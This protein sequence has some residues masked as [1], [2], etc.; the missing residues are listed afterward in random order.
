MFYVN[1]QP[2]NNK[3]RTNR[4]FS[5]ANYFFT[6]TLLSRKFIALI[7]T[8]I[9]FCC[10]LLTSDTCSQVYYLSTI[11]SSQFIVQCLQSTFH[12]TSM[13]R[14]S[15]KSSKSNTPTLGS[16][17]SASLQEDTNSS[18][19]FPPQKHVWWTVSVLFH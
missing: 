3:L 9:L 7:S 12:M 10:W 14:Y 17:L 8:L 6:L 4:H 11:Y 13:Y 15:H 2:K 16:M 5:I 1:I 19:W 18:S